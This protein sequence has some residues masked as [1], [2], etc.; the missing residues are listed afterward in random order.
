MVNYWQC[1]LQWRPEVECYRN[2]VVMVGLGSKKSSPLR[3]CLVDIWLTVKY[4]ATITCCLRLSDT[5]KYLSCGFGR[6][7]GFGERRGHG[8]LWQNRFP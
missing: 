4:I 7:S 5:P 8:V 6:R 2:Q 3:C 1:V